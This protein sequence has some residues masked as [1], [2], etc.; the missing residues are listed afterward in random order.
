MSF[1]ENCA[2]CNII[3]VMSL[4]MENF[5]LNN[6]TSQL[7]LAYIKDLCKKHLTI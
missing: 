3:L 2:Q 5:E 4:E 1:E 7:P 6:E